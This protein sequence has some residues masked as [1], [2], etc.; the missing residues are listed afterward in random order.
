YEARA[1]H[2]S[3]HFRQASA[4][5]YDPT[6]PT[7]YAQVIFL[8]IS[9]KLQLVFYDPTDQAMCAWVINSGLSSRNTFVKREL[10]IVTAHRAAA[11][12]SYK[13][14][15]LFRK[16]LLLHYFLLYNI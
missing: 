14:F 9:G 3:Q 5:F 8:N 10:N 6:S 1:G 13:I 4:R 15:A 7:R 11:A 16:K 12:N 2:I